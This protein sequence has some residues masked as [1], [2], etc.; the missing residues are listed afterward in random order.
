LRSLVQLIR[1]A[2]P[3]AT[4]VETGSL[5]QW[6]L[7]QKH[8]GTPLPTDYKNFID[9]YGTGSFDKRLIPFNPFAKNESVNLIQVLDVYHQASRKTQPLGDAPWSA[10][11][12]FELFPAT[13]GLLPWG[14]TANFGDSFLW[15]VNGPPEAWVTIT[16]N[17]RN[18]EYEV[19]KLSFTNFL[20][21]LL[22]KEIESVVLSDDSIPITRH[23]QFN[24]E[25]T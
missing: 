6:D 18:G 21:K 2:P 8:L 10:F 9:R 1:I 16:Y 24:P 13:E 25:A 4:P 23:L 17:L 12:P 19:W 15:Q 5:K 3:P 14:T 20:V 11:H 22:L 7:V